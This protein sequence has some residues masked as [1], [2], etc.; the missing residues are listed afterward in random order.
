[1]GRISEPNWN[2]NAIASRCH[3]AKPVCEATSAPEVIVT[4]RGVGYL[5]PKDLR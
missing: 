5:V 2:A 1:M 4:V 3:G